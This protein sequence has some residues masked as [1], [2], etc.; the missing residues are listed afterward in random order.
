MEFGIEKCAR[1]E[2]RSGKPHIK[3]GIELRNQVIRTPGEKENYK[4]LGI[5]EGD[6]IIQVEMKEKNLKNSISEESE[7]YSRQNF[8]A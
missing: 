2:M 8:I 5:L 7:N 3:E 6:M 1:L 4:Y